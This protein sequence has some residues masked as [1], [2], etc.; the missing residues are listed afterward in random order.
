MAG[1]KRGKT[2][3]RS[4]SQLVSALT[5]RGPHKV[6]R[7]DLGIVGISGQVF[8][9]A[10]GSRLPAIAFGHS[11]GADSRR[12]RDLLL[13]LASWGIV[14]AAPDG[15]RGF[16]PSDV[17]LAADLRAT[18]TAVSS[19]S[20]GLGQVTVD[21]RRLGLAGHGFGASAA[22]IAASDERLLGQQAPSIGAVAGLFPAPTTSILEPAA[23]RVQ[24]PGMFVATAGDLDSVDANAL[25]LTRAYGGDVTLRTIGGVSRGLLEKRSVKSLIGVNGANRGTHGVARALLVGFFLHQLTDDPEY[26]AFGDPEQALGAASP[27]DLDDPPEDGLDMVSRL[28][29]AKP[30]KK[31]SRVR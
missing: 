27:V 8:T 22:V 6:L 21:P 7:G 25:R 26:Q 9:P 5:R 15:Q 14:A 13:H 16:F 11:W 12:Y 28:V 10:E 20:L 29:G 2:P 4:P 30:P 3:S 31:R 18:L 23:A 1:K 17:A 24:A 19:V